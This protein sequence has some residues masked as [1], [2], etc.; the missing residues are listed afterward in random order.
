M[1][2]GWLSEGSMLDPDPCPDPRRGKKETL[3][4]VRID[5]TGTPSASHLSVQVR[6]KEHDGT[7][8]GVY[9]ICPGER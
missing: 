7:G 2:E 1:A 6:V 3:N 5:P 4:S 8:Q 9:R